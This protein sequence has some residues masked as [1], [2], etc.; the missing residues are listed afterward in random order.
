MNWTMIAF[1]AVM[2]FGLLR[3]ALSIEVLACAIEGLDVE[4]KTRHL[5]LA[6]DNTKGRL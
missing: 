2:A 5:R 6:V 1:G 4:K 3:L